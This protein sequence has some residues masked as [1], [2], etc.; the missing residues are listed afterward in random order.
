MRIPVNSALIAVELTVCSKG[1][2][3]WQ[4]TTCLLTGRV[5]FTDVCSRLY[6]PR[7]VNCTKVIINLVKKKI[8]ESHFL[9]CLL[10]QINVFISVMLCVSPYIHL[11]KFRILDC[12]FAISLSTNVII[13]NEKM[14]ETK[15]MIQ[16]TI[17]GLSYTVCLE[18]NAR[19]P[20]IIVKLPQRTATGVLYKQYSI[21][22]VSAE[23]QA[24]SG[25]P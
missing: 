16:S 11:V 10:W 18:T 5:L 20:V 12:R 9:C 8:N 23:W 24:L 19:V 17:V 2:N 3:Q 14:C 22:S 7:C 13:G 15:Y 21:R 25:Y 4:W 6:W 1:L